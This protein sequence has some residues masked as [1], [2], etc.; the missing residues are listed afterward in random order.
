MKKISK[1]IIIL[2]T[3]LFIIISIIN[4]I[5][6]SYSSNYIDKDIDYDEISYVLV[7]GAGIRNNYPSLMLKDRLD[8]AIDLY[9][10]NNN[11]KLI[12]S[13]DSQ[14]EK[15]YNEVGV[16]Y[17]Y[18]KECGVAEDNIILDKLGIST[19]DSIK[20]IKNIVNNDKVIIVTQKYQLT[21]SIY[22]ARNNNINCYGISSY[23]YKYVGQL[24]R[25]LREILARVKDYIF[26]KLNISPKY[27]VA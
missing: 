27:E 13:G 1:I 20:R 16:M 26:V 25:D 21:R 6:I 2:I 22:I 14:N 17:N 12:L 10:K 23:N 24:K 4:I 15:N 19:Y 7:L 18:V 11:I 5:M 8:K 3:I 9:K